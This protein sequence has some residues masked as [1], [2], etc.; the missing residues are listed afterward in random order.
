MDHCRALDAELWNEIDIGDRFFPEI[1]YIVYDVSRLGEPGRIEPH[2][3]N[4]SQVTVVV[5]LSHESEFQGGLNYFEPGTER[6]ESR[7]AKLKR[8]DAVFFYG[9]RCEHWISPVVSGRRTILQMESC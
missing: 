9:D 8:G 1:E 3:D 4:Q 7:S 6:G 5:M 2:T